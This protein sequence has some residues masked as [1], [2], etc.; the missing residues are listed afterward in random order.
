AR[1]Q[2]AVDD[3]DRTIRDI[4]GYIFELRPSVVGRAPLDQ[5]LRDLVAR[6]REGTSLLI[7]VDIDPD[8][9]AA[10]EEHGEDLVQIA[11]E[12]LSNAL[13]HSK[14]T[15]VH[16]TLADGPGGVELR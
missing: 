15:A 9:A 8:S 13:R 1:V 2:A 6:L 14:G 3:I 10:V 5:V 11:R 4:R 7:H 12:A 16:L